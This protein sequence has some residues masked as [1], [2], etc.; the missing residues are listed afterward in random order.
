MRNIETRLIIVAVLVAASL[1]DSEAKE[2]RGG[3]PELSNAEKVNQQS[4]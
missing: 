3:Q 1:V 2:K 4:T